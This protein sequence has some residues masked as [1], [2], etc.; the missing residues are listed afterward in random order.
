MSENGVKNSS[1][2]ELIAL[3]QQ[4]AAELGRSPA[5]KDVELATAATAIRRFGS[6]NNFLVSAGLEAKNRGNSPMSDE[7]AI[8]LVQAKAAELGRTPKRIEFT[9]SRAV[10]KKYGGWEN[11]LLAA[12]LEPPEM[13]KY[14]QISDK[15][16]IELVQAR[17]AELGRTPKKYEFVQGPTAANRYGGWSDFLRA[18]NLE[19]A[20]MKKHRKHQ[21]HKTPKKQ[22]SDEQ[23]IELVQARAAELGRTPKRYEFAQGSTATNRFGSWQSFLD[24]AGLEIGKSR[25]KQKA[26]SDNQLMELVQAQA[27]ELDRPPHKHEFAYN[28]PACDRFGGWEF[29]LYRAG[30]KNTKPKKFQKMISDDQLMEKAR[31]QA[32][33]LGRPPKKKEFKHGA[34]AVNRYG[35]WVEFLLAAGLKPEKF[36]QISNERLVELIRAETVELGRVPKREESPFCKIAINRYGG[37]YNFLKAVEQMPASREKNILK[38][39][40]SQMLQLIKAQAVELNRT[41]TIIEFEYAELAKDKFRSWERFLK[42]AGLE[43]IEPPEENPKIKVKISNEQL[44]ERVQAQAAELGRTP[45]IREFEHAPVAIK[46]FG[47]WSAFLKSAG[48]ELLKPGRSG[49]KITNEQ[50]IERVQARAAELGRTPTIREF[51][52]GV[53]ATGRFG[54]WGTFLKSAGLAPVKPVSP[55]PKISNEELTEMVQAQAAELGRTP[56]RNEFK[57]GRLVTSRFGT[58]SAFLQGVGLE[59]VKPMKPRLKISNEQLLDLVKERAL[60]LGRTPKKYEFKHGMLATSRFGTWADFLKS[61]ALEPVKPVKSGYKISNEQLLELVKER[62]VQIGRSPSAK[63]FR[64]GTLVI[65]RFGSWDAFLLEAGLEP[66]KREPLK[67]QLNDEE[68]IAAIKQRA[69]ELER[70]PKVKDFERASLACY[71]FGTWNAFLRKAGL[72]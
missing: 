15:Q 29:F 38:I 18:A 24:S 52:Y 68:L 30:L 33:E 67:A 65:G 34:L 2:E 61:A 20:K 69:I 47:V 26:P 10:I 55:G 31:T 51:Q 7:E 17:A 45:T 32:A 50:L 16:L 53:L 42:S 44:I 43:P 3:I 58:W 63:E 35:S 37:W 21:R 25:E 11:F 14:K 4:K 9:Q 70:I 56:K 60:E 6:W 1:N 28:K 23:L 8:R 39:S 64:Y 12:G 62:T 36:I 71:R 46:R 57:H 72:I 48:L 22:F 66:T 27:A 13:K 40:N 54:T 19:P 41:P 49:Y 5:H 59:P